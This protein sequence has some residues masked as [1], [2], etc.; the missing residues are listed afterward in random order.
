MI[1]LIGVCVASYLA[2]GIPFSYLAG[3]ITRGVDLRNFGSGNLGAT[4]TY[5]VLGGRIA[6]VVLV[7]DIAKGFLPV[8]AALH[9]LSS[10]SVPTH[11]LGVAAM[12]FSILGHLFSP[13]LGF[14]GG[15]GIATS[16]G[17]F[18]ALAP[19]AFLGALI[20]FAL[21]FAASR[22]VSLG[23]LCAAVVL[24]PFV[25]ISARAG[26][27]PFEWSIEGVSILI[28]LIV[29]VKHRSNLRRLLS[30]TEKKL[31]RVKSE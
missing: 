25:Y 17:A 5:R 29:I 19:W 10:A 30:G 3:R 31:A 27:A 16:A 26:L 20:V 15:K 2:G 14:A 12:F 9:W 8:F 24:P 4:N 21:V 6:V 23:S 28:M 22:I 13:Y 1:V 7:L 11:W 18:A